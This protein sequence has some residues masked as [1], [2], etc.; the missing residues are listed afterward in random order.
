MMDSKP[1]WVIVPPKTSEREQS[2]DHYPN[3]GIE[4]WHKKRK[5][6]S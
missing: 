2:F 5:L 3:E 1:D 6:A 4:D